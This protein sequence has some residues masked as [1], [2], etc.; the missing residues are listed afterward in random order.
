[1]KLRFLIILAAFFA[2]VYNTATAQVVDSTFYKAKRGHYVAFEAGYGLM[3]VY[4]KMTDPG[5]STDLHY[6]A[7]ARFSYRWYILKNWAIGTGLHYQQMG[8]TSKLQNIQRITDAVDE[9]G[10]PIEHRTIFHDVKEDMH[11][12]IVSIPAGMHFHGGQLAKRM[13]FNAG[14]GVMFNFSMENSY[15]T[16]GEIETRLYYDQ[17]HLEL[18]DV[19]GHNVYRKGGFSGKYDLIPSIS[20]FGELG[21]VYSL[22]RRIDL[23]FNVLGAYSINPIINS[24]KYVYDPDC[25]TSDGY[26]DLKY[27]GVLGSDEADGV[28]LVNIGAMFGVRYRIGTYN[29]TP[30]EIERERRAREMQHADFNRTQRQ[31]FERLERQRREHEEDSIRIVEEERRQRAIKE[32]EFIQQKRQR[33]SIAR[34]DSI[35]RA[36]EAAHVEAVLTEV[37]RLELDSLIAVLNRNHCKFNNEEVILTNTQKKCLDR[38]AFLM[39][40]FPS[41]N[42]ICIG[43]TCDIGNELRNEDIGLQRA[44]WFAQ[45]LVLRGVNPARIECISKGFKEPLVPNTS[46]KNREKNRRIEIKRK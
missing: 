32:A 9:L 10:R 43:H 8:T 40:N 2:V 29:L 42:L 14:G 26:K 20:V 21:L 46:E 13:K 16:S 15:K 35:K 18:G 17:Y 1:M 6:G 39:V 24:G 36:N 33:D 31:E 27:N 22:N 7:Q 45:E 25:L 28:R 12:H 11:T 37:V 38:L 44:K 34:V 5:N 4:H 3:S 23:T 30:E 41:I 19:E